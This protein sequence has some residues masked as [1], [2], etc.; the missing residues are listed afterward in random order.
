MIVEVIKR[1]SSI[2]VRIGPRGRPGPAG[3][4]GSGSSAWEDITDKPSTFPPSSHTHAMS[5]VTGLEAALGTLCVAT[6]DSDGLFLEFHLYG[7]G[8]LIGKVLLN[9]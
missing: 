3:D 6:V 9:S 5:E 1:L 4:P 8:T 2:E 7:S